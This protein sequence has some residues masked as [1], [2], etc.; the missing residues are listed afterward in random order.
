MSGSAAAA[1]TAG[2]SA[3]VKGRSSTDS[4]RTVMGSRIR[5]IVAQTGTPGYPGWPC[6]RPWATIGSGPGCRPESLH[7]G[8]R[9]HEQSHPAPRPSPGRLGRVP[10]APAQRG[11]GA[12][13]RRGGR[14]VRRGHRASG[15]GLP[16]EEGP[17]G[18][19]GR[20]RPHLGRAHRRAREADAAT[21]V[22]TV[23]TRRPI[24]SSTSRSPAPASTTP[25]RTNCTSPC[26]SPATTR[27]RSATTTAR[28]TSGAARRRV[29]E[30]ARPAAGRPGPGSRTRTPS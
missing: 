16:G 12:V 10:A 1:S 11:R 8:S 7:P 5:I 9:N 21:T 30:D 2:A 15:Q 14:Q 28:W 25:T 17:E 26:S 23:T 3:G 6:P 20:R 29:R 4:P 24:R 27:S 19:R 18:R 22:T 13:H